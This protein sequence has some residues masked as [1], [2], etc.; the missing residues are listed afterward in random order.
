MEL[1]STAS[2]IPFGNP[3]STTLLCR[4]KLRCQ[5]A[6]EHADLNVFLKS[7]K[8]PETFDS[9][10]AEWGQGFI[11]PQFGAL[12]KGVQSVTP[13]MI[14]PHLLPGVVPNRM[15]PTILQRA[16]LPPWVGQG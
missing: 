13:D 12:G 8:T 7:S 5:R 2:T 9:T 1:Q 14:I 10:L 6:L 16:I 15:E 4:D 3:F 11:K